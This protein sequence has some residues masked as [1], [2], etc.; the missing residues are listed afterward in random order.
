VF[1]HPQFGA[2]IAETPS[3]PTSTYQGAAVNVTSTFT[4][5]NI[6]PAITVPSQPVPAGSATTVTTAVSNAGPGTARQVGTQ[7]NLP[8][9][10][11]AQAAGPT[12][13]PTLSA[14][15][16]LRTTWNVTPAPGATPIASVGL[17]A[18]TTYT[19]PDGSV[20]AVDSP[21]TVVVTAPLQSPFRSTAST[22]AFFGQSG[23]QFAIEAAGADIFQ[24]GTQASDDYGAIY[25][26]GAATA[27]TTATVHVD[28][29]QNTDAWAKAG[30]V[31]R[32]DLTKNHLSPGYVALVV[33]PG[34][35]VSLQ[36]DGDGNGILDSFVAAG[37]GSVHA[38]VWL[39]LV[40]SN[41]TY[42]GFYSTDGSTWT[43]VGGATV[44]SAASAEDVGM[45]A[46]AHNNAQ[47][48][49]NNFSG[50]TLTHP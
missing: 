19:A 24:N 1:V 6:G 27:T 33:T 41:T 20:G 38:P 11:A 29:Q 46:T 50:F 32:N 10:W 40:R 17:V 37:A 5:V 47:L 14:G 4:G 25:Q 13:T 49:M 18:H 45:I 31:M 34:N 21:A 48:G 2:G 39:R 8:S 15:Q 22:Q 3:A 44:G 28:A 23:T 9:G 36:W 16:T 35:G 43:Q 26:T 42:T 7:L 30:L 12:S